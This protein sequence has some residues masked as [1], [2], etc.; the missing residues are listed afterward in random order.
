MKIVIVGA[1]GTIGKGIVHLLSQS[2]DL[3]KVGLRSGDFTLDLASKDSIQKLFDEVGAF[4]A[5]ISAAGEATFGSLDE[6]TDE[7]FMLALNSKLMGQI[8]LVRLGRSYIRDGGSFTLTSGML[9]QH[10][11][12]GRMP[13]APFLSKRPWKSSAWTAPMACPRKKSPW[14]IRR[15]RKV[16]STG[17]SWMSGILP[18]IYQSRLFL[19]I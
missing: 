4:D 9:S 11:M 17:K 6:L 12:S 8:N 1:S 13:S 3:V 7:N 10:P 5:V 19:T 2:H 16:S 18:E 14:L 15:Q